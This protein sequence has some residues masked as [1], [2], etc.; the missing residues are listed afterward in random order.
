MKFLPFGLIIPLLLTAAGP[1]IASE[2]GVRVTDPWVREGPPSAAVLAAF[3]VI[4]NN[5]QQ[6]ATVARVTSPQFKRIEMHR[7][8]IQNGV[9]R[10]IPQPNLTIPAGKELVLKPGSYHLMLFDPSSPMMAGTTVELTLHMQDGS[11]LKIPAPVRKGMGAGGMMHHQ[12]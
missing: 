12:Q 10:M 9:A 11:E 8:E 1:C 4:R 6:T 3:M 7:T 5:S 2:T